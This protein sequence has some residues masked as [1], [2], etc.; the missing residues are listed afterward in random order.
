MMLLF[1]GYYLSSTLM[2]PYTFAPG[3]GNSKIVAYTGLI[4]TIVVISTL[5]Y[6]LDMFGV[7]GAGVNL[8][9]FETISIVSGVIITVGISS[10][11]NLLSDFGCQI[12]LIY[13]FLG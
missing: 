7:N 6:L 13:C 9:L 11:R 2:I 5:P 4:Q 10:Y 12:D 3:V 1:V 8:I